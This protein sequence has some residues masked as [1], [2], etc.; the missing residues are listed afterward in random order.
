M[1]HIAGVHIQVGPR[2]R[3]RCG[4]CGATLIDYD[5][6]N[7]AVPVGQDAAPGTW[8]AGELVRVDG[9]LSIL[10]EHVDGTDLPVDACARLDHAVTR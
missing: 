8:P 2:L 3:Q 5:L 9:P 4:W 10:M 1:V 7:V 6:E